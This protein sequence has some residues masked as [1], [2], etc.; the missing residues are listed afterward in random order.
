MFFCLFVSFWLV[1]VVVVVMLFQEVVRLKIFWPFLV[2]V[3]VGLLKT[4][5]ITNYSAGPLKSLKAYSCN[6]VKRK[7]ESLT[8]VFTH[9]CSHTLYACIVW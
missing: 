4:Q 1:V 2:L 8:L 5:S 6:Q 9:L 3:F 7:K